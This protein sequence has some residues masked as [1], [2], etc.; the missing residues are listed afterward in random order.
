M[1]N[2]NRFHQDPDALPPADVRFTELR[3][4]P[5]PDGRRVRVHVSLTPFQQNPNLDAVISD[6]AG[7]EIAHSSIIEVADVRFVFTMHIRSQ[8]VA[9]QYNL[10]ARLSYED[11]GTIEERSIP[12]ETAETRDDSSAQ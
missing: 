1:L 7:Q 12:F 4:E 9:G 11:I 5:W 6:D 3:V 8:T 2:R 10:V